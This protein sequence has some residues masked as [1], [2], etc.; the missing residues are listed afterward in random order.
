MISKLEE[1]RSLSWIYDSFEE[2]I[3]KFKTKLRY[4]ICLWKVTG[5]QQ[6]ILVNRPIFFPVAGT[7]HRH[8]NKY[9][10]STGKFFT[11]SIA[12]NRQT[13]ISGLRLFIKYLAKYEWINL[14]LHKFSLV[15][16]LINQLEN[17]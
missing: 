8:C 12:W 4:V 14:D 10:P 15:E 17:V 1:F 11:G 6:A 2:I 7:S 5:C 13:C 9:C 16:L 3:T